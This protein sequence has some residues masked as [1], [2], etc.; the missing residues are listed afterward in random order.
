MRLL[1][2]RPPLNKKRKMRCFLLLYAILLTGCLRLYSMPAYPKRI[3]IKTN[4]GT[5]YI[6]LWGDERSK[7]AE[8]IDGYTIVQKGGQWFYAEKDSFGLLRPSSHKLA[9]KSNAATQNFL[10]TTPYHLRANSNTQIQKASAK[11]TSHKRS[12][13]G[14]RKVL[15]ILMQFNDYKM[16]K[17]HDDFHRLFNQTEYTEDGA[18]GSVRDFFLD[19]SYGQLQLVCD[20]VGPFTSQHSRNYYGGNDITGNDQHPEELFKEAIQE[21]SAQVNLK[22]YDSDG[23]GFIDNVHIIFAGHGEEAGAS[24]EAIWS[25]EMTFFIPYEI[26]GVKIDCYSCAPE[27]RGNSGEGISRIGPHCHEIGHA[28]GSM[29]YYDVDYS[30]NDHYE[31]T[32]DW[33]V[34]ASGSWN[35]DGIRPAD[36][37][38]YVKAFDFGWISPKPLPAGKVAMPASCN[39]KDNYFKLQLN[40]DGDIYLLENRSKE[41]WGGATPGEGLLVFH[42]HADIRQAGNNINSTAPQKCYIV[43]ASSQI[44][45]PGSSPSSYGEI[46]SSG[47]PYPGSSHNTNFGQQSTPMAFFWN[48]D[49][50]N[51]EINDIKMDN[52]GTIHFVN[53]S[54]GIDDGETERRR[55]FFEDFE[56]ENLQVY[57]EDENLFPPKWQNVENTEVPLKRIERPYAYSG[58]RCLQLSAKKLADSL[59]S[60]LNFEFSVPKSSKKMILTLRVNSVNLQSDHH[61]KLTISFHSKDSLE[62]ET[63][64]FVST[65][66]NKWIKMTTVLPQNIVTPIHI[67][68]TVYGNSV[69]A[70]DDIEVVQIICDD[71]TTG[72]SNGTLQK[73]ASGIYSLSGIRL[74]QLQKGLNVIV[75]DDGTV[76]KVIVN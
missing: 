52:D 50:C 61:N 8:T 15:V 34:M 68:G 37:N 49:E 4:N 26:Q 36:F 24:D 59:S 56:D 39:N 27:L 62:W 55:L 63:V 1:Q 75:K 6:R 29:D 23:D 3:P 57:I 14:I 76:R 44:S 19:A 2:T 69:L 35:D 58:V 66:E 51:I 47:F 42:V 25:H 33:D 5:V 7:V 21:A 38:P 13:T 65:E 20:V 10:E 60:N 67:E 11:S 31:G 17:K 9:A 43:C 45:I 64:R 74:S 40:D 73:A 22:D 46:N 16:V 72:I 18:L 12:A 28:L 70:I 32:G 30:A 53:N 41:K 71:E 54:M 48:H